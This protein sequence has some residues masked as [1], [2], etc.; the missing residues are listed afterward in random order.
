MRLALFG[1]AVV[2]A[3]VIPGLAQAGDPRLLFEIRPPVTLVLENGVGRDALLAIDARNPGDRRVRVE[4]V[5]A[6]YFEGDT[7][8]GKIG[9]AHV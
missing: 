8:V 1:A 3:L 4:R 2:A 5:R 7:A 9:R 6:T